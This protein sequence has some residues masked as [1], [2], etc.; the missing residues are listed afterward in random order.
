M[1]WRSGPSGVSADVQGQEG[2]VDD[3]AGERPEQWADDGA[4]L[5]FAARHHLA[6]PGSGQWV[7]SARRRTAPRTPF[8]LGRPL[9]A[10]GTVAETAG[11]LR[12]VGRARSC[13]GE[14]LRRPPRPRGP[15]CMTRVALF[16]WSATSSRE[17]VLGELEEQAAARGAVLVIVLEKGSSGRKRVRLSQQRRS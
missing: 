10:R 14:L 6:S 9:G 5:L 4:R 16:C 17:H 13:L 12:A 2:L 3:F 11:A 1:P 15:T 8:E 7:S